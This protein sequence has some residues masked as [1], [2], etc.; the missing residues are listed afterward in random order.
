MD[1]QK[2]RCVVGMMMVLLGSGCAFTVEPEETLEVVTLV[3]LTTLEPPAASVICESS[4]PNGYETV[5]VQIN[6][7]EVSL[8]RASGHRTVL[9]WDVEHPVVRLTRAGWFLA[10][11]RREG[12]AFWAL[13]DSATGERRWELNPEETFAEFGGHWSPHA[14]TEAGGLVVTGLER[15]GFHPDDELRHIG[16]VDTAGTLTF[17]YPGLRASGRPLLDGWLAIQTLGDRPT[18]HACRTSWCLDG[19]REGP[20]QIGWLSADSGELVWGFNLAPRT[21]VLSLGSG[22]LALRA[23]GEVVWSARRS[24]A[25][26][27]D[28][29]GTGLAVLRRL[30]SVELLLDA[31][32]IHDVRI[33]DQD[34]SRVLVMAR[35]PEGET[36]VWLFRLESGGSL[37]AKQLEAPVALHPIEPCNGGDTW[38]LFGTTD[39]GSRSAAGVVSLFTDGRTAFLFQDSFDGEGWQPLGTPMT[40]IDTVAVQ[41]AGSMVGVMSSER[42]STFCPGLSP[43]DPDAPLTVD[44]L[45]G[46]Y[47]QVVNLDDPLESP[48]TRRAAPGLSHDLFWPAHESGDCWLYR[49][50]GGVGG[51]FSFIDPLTGSESY[52][53]MGGHLVLMGSQ[54]VRL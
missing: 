44:R 43:H 36:Q 8:L 45:E 42:S 7:G 46:G 53:E 10:E 26:S 13:F 11:G 31:D 33:V 47:L 51:S 6:E 24:P 48:T 25:S 5:A 28:L 22:S 54:T 29:S 35:L 21:R 39:A 23:D 27:V 2:L 32:A 12:V 9:S 41:V 1:K 15:F 20:S 14:L 17:A 52:I 30:L 37:S 34:A 49:P 19:L 16:T 50:A 38:A 3:S 4:F 40:E 18:E